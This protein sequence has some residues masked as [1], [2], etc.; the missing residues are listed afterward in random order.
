MAV[1]PLARIV[2]GDAPKTIADGPPVPVKDVT[3]HFVSNKSPTSSR[4]PG[5]IRNQEP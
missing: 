4:L 5:G 1:T 2:A 3:C